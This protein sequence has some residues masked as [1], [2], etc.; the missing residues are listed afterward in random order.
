MDHQQ[1]QP[2]LIWF[3]N[4][5]VFGT[6]S[7][8]IQK[9]F[10]E[11]MGDYSVEALCS[12]NDLK[13]SASIRQ[14]KL[15]LKIVNISPID[16]EIIIRSDIALDSE[17]NITEISAMPEDENTMKNHNNVFPHVYAEA[18]DGKYNIGAYTVSIIETEF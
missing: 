15:I 5:N 9:L 4:S 10:S 11:H 3:D 8:Y 14:N 7:Y 2:N 17:Y 6:P 18:L 1:W 12:D 13:I 16:K